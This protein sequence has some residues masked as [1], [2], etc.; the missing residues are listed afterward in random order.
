LPECTLGIVREDV[1]LVWRCEPGEGGFRP[2][3]RGRLDRVDSGIGHAKNAADGNNSIRVAMR[4][5]MRSMGGKTHQA[6]SQKPVA[7]AAWARETD[8]MK[9]ADKACLGQVSEESGRNMLNADVA[10]KEFN[11][12][13][14][15]ILYFAKAK[16]TGALWLK[17]PAAPAG[18]KATARFRRAHPETLRPSPPRR[19]NPRKQSQSYNR[20]P[21]E[22]GRR[23]EGVG[24]VRVAMKAGNSA[25][26]M[27]PCWSGTP[28]STRGGRSV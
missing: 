1:D 3:P 25:G 17:C 5:T 10:S 16:R 11:S 9:P 27:G 7:W 28:P 26:A 8:P 20:S 15:A 13:S 2:L 24:R 12:G 21:R 19:R 6:K 23:R 22:M 4:R 14:R 18:C